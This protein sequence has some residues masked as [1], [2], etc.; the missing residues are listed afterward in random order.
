MIVEKNELE[1][2]TL[3]FIIITLSY[4]QRESIESVL[5]HRLPH[6]FAV[7][8][9]LFSFSVLW[10][11]SSSFCFHS[12]LYTLHHKHGVG[13]CTYIPCTYILLQWI[14][15]WEC[16]TVQIIDNTLWN[17]VILFLKKLLLY[18]LYI[19]HLLFG[20][21]SLCSGREGMFFFYL[22]LLCSWSFLWPCVLCQFLP[23]L[24][25][26]T[27]QTPCLAHS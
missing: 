7:S 23:F 17:I 2:F 11:L 25:G 26:T 24:P 4:S 5:H 10:A 8:C 27:F 6:L 12:S 20:H 15:Q 21:L 16:S 13:P 9:F 18:K 1:S 3:V 19:P 14:S 22:S